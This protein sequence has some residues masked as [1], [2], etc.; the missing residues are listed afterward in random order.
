MMREQKINLNQLGLERE[1][2][3]TKWFLMV[4]QVT[5]MRPNPLRLSKTGCAKDENPNIE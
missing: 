4:S 1:G 2:G 5:P 3:A